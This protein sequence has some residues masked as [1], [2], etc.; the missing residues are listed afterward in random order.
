MKLDRAEFDRR[1]AAGN[2]KL[3]LIGM[4][5]IGKSY[6][7]MRLATQFD[8]SLIEVDRL[9]WDALGE[10]DMDAFAAWQGQPYSA[11]YAER[12]RQSMAM[13]S[14]ATQKSL[15]TTARNPLLDTTGSVIYTD[16]AVL[17]QIRK[18]WFTVYIEA[19]PEHLDRLKSQYFAQPKPLAWQEHYQKRDGLSETES[20]LASYPDL[21]AARADD[22]RALADLTISSVDILTDDADALFALIKPAV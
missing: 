2:L 17:D 16:A 22:Y 19:A 20:L 21:L 6:S 7:G 14:D 5:N 15:T 9:I 10:T 4:S 18:D 13:E 11:G 1:Y 12:E 8:F 3:A